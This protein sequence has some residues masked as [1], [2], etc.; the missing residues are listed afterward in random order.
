MDFDC[1]VF[2]VR[3]FLRISSHHSLAWD[4]YNNVDA[5]AFLRHTI[6][7]MDPS[8]TIYW[9]RHQLENGVLIIQ[10]SCIRAGTRFS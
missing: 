4:C 1:K 8:Q 10:I 9:N 7:C 5:V 3:E 2:A 6:Y